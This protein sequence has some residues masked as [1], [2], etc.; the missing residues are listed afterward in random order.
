M[1]GYRSH[2]LRSPWWEVPRKYRTLYWRPGVP[3]S[4][5]SRPPLPPSPLCL[6]GKWQGR[7]WPMLPFPQLLQWLPWLCCRPL[8][9][10]ATLFPG[11]SLLRG[12]LPGGTPLRSVAA[13]RGRS[14]TSAIPRLAI[15]ILAA[16]GTRDVAH[17]PFRAVRSATICYGEGLGFR[18]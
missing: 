14:R 16:P 1:T 4:P 18:V 9:G 2:E 5:L 11:P 17:V 12:A 8:P 3:P 10:A 6:M 7:S 13:P 15:L